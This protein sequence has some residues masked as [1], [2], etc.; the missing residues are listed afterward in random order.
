VAFSWTKAKLRTN[1]VGQVAYLD[2]YSPGYSALDWMYRNIL[3]EWVR[4]KSDS[5]LRIRYEDLIDNP[6]NTLGQI[7]SF[8]G[9]SDVDLSFIGPSGLMFPKES[10]AIAGNPM[11]FEQRPVVLHMDSAWQRNFGAGDKR[12][13]TALSWPLLKRYAYL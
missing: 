10:H 6:K 13:V 9:I 12:V 2:R 1:L 5:Y 7:A 8:M 4:P 11:R 3:T